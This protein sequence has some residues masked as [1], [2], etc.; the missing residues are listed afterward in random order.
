[1]PKSFHSPR[2]LQ[3]RF[4]SALWRQR[5][6]FVQL[7]LREVQGRYRGSVLG[8]TWSLITPLLML[9]VYTFV[10]SQVFRARWGDL[11]QSGPL[12]FA[13]NLFAGLIVYGVFSETI[14][15]AP[16]RIT[17]SANLA[18][19]LI[20]PLEILSAVT[21]ATALFHAMTSLVVL[22]GFQI[23][24]QSIAAPLGETIGNM[25]GIQLT[26]LWV[27]LVWVPLLCGCLAL[28]WILSALGVYLR[29]LSQVTVVMANLMMFLSAVF[30]PLSALPDKWQPLLQV[31]P[32]VLIIEQ[33]RRVAISGLGPSPSYLVFGIIC[34]LIF[35]EIAYRLFQKARGGFGD[36][37]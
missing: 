30:Y 21:V 12:V 29:D 2:A 4:I 13:I 10:F 16:T 23:I 14:C 33:T 32:L 3:L 1:M 11:E 6:L 7:T 19:K 22:I 27:P 34:S 8:W 37:L 5:E 18:T 26:L 20:F 9:G 35:A 25:P 24:N 17:S 15:Q 28:G 31:N 36:V